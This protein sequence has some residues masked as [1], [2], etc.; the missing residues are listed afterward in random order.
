MSFPLRAAFA[1]LALTSFACAAERDVH[2]FANPEHVRVRHVA[3]DLDVD[4]DRRE[5]RGTALLGV[6]RTSKDTTQPLVLDTRGLT[7]S[8]VETLTDGTAF[9]KA[10]FDLG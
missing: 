2:S 6:E 5:I 3:L 10:K 1:M 4:F 9:Y 7:I 8:N